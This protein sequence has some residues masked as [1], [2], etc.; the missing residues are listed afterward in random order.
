MQGEH[1]RGIYPVG[2]VQPRGGGM[3]THDTR[4]DNLITLSSFIVL[5]C[6]LRKRDE[7]D[8]NGLR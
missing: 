5:H 7:V 8:A 4:S 1:A 6:L 2:G 3:E